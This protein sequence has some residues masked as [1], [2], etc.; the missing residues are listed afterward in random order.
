VTGI[1]YVVSVNLCFCWWDVHDSICVLF[2]HSSVFWP[3]VARRIYWGF[4]WWDRS[5]VVLYV[6]V[7]SQGYVGQNLAVGRV[8]FAWVVYE[9]V[10]VI[11][12]ELDFCMEARWV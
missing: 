8:A 5:Y 4:Y 9:R 3:C 6:F 1:L 10:L 11:A 12:C 2:G 7:L